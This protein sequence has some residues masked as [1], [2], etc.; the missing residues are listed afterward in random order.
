M[1]S[2]IGHVGAKVASEQDRVLAEQPLPSSEDLL[3]GIGRRRRRAQ[4]RTRAILA[5]STALVVLLAVSFGA[6]LHAPGGPP[7][8]AGTHPPALGV[9]RAVTASVPLSFEDGTKMVVMPG[10]TADLREVHEHGA[11]IALEDGSMNLDVVH[12]EASRW[13]VNAGPF[14]IR[15]TGT[16]FDATWDAAAKRLTVAMTE[17]TV[18]VS[19][20]CVNEFLSAPH[21]KVFECNEAAPRAV[22]A[23]AAVSSATSPSLA[24]TGLPTAQVAPPSAG[25]LVTD[26]DKARLAGDTV[27]ARQ[28][29]AQVRERFPGT[30]HAGKSAF[31]LGRMADAGDSPEEAVRWFEMAARERGGFASEAV[32]RL[33]ELEQKRGNTARARALALEYLQKYP[34]GPHGAYAKSIVDAHR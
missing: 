32:G 11:L 29:Y 10:A 22:A 26:A 13:Q 3:R 23:V 34:N 8:V 2:T 18:L 24:V 19:G 15:V 27:R 30:D 1:S 21:R 31:L 33:M 5:L 16:K 6:R 9:T 28:L 20:P 14:G 12:T 17:G 25:L 7:V 4:N